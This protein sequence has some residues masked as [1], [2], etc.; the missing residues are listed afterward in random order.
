MDHDLALQTNLDDLND[1]QREAVQATSGPLVILAGAGT[2]K[3]RVISRRAAYAIDTGVVA[4]DRILLVTFTDKAAREMVARMR[5]LGHPRVMARTFHAHALSQLRYFWPRLHDGAEPPQT[6][7]SKLPILVPLARRLPG[8]YRFTPV[9]DLADTIEWA[10]VQRIRPQRWEQDA[11]DRAPI[12]PDLFARLYRDYEQAKSRRGLIDFEDMLTL[13][14]ELLESDAQAAATVQRAKTWI[15]VDEYQDTNPLQERLLELWLGASIDLAVV[16]DPNQTI[17]TFTG[18]SP[19][20]LL[21]FADRH[22]G[23]R[24]IAL[25]DNY[26]SSPQVLGLANRLI[27][28]TEGAGLRPTRPPGPTPTIEPHPTSEHELDALVGGVRRLLADGV[29]AP[30]IAVLVRMNAQLA[31]IEQALTRAG[32]PFT[33]RGQRFFERRDVRAARELVKRALLDAVG[34]ALPE[35]VTALLAERLGFGTNIDGAG[36]EGREQQAALEVL[37]GILFDLVVSLPEATAADFTAELDRRDAAE[38]AAQGSGVNL[39]TYHKAKGL[40]WDAV[41]LPALDEGTLPIRHAKTDDALAEERRLLYVGI[42]RARLHLALSWSARPSRFLA[43]LRPPGSVRVTPGAAGAVAAR[44]RPTS[45]NTALLEALQ[46]WRRERAKSDAVPA[47][48]IAHDATLAAIADD[49]P[50]SLAALRRVKGMG[51]VK[52]NSYGDEILA[53]VAGGVLTDLTGA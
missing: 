35:A 1:A 6:I 24:T 9:K 51:P 34:P 31:P 44:P 20:F 30:E 37:V 36:E 17:Y 48:V 27:S 41:F 18:A 26:R 32:I 14:V 10:K 21:S 38:R 29:A 28:S 47:Y 15:S 2:G 43:D 22:I 50:Q 16:G 53:I 5:A 8:G 46:L 4:V 52:V 42:T 12:P 3:T 49:R 23:A 40:E 39:A 19:E 25:T 13:T 7:D 33:V 11:P 45:A